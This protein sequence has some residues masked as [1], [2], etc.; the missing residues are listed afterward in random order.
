MK[1]IAKNGITAL[2][3]VNKDVNLNSSCKPTKYIS[4]K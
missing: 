4:A 2:K 1:N 3:C